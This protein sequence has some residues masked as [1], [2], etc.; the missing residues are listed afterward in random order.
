SD[1][2]AGARAS[3]KGIG[4]IA[5]RNITDMPSRATVG[6]A[7]HAPSVTAMAIQ[8]SRGMRVTASAASAAAVTGWNVTGGA[9]TRRTAYG[10]VAAHAAERRQPLAELACG[11][12]GPAAA[13]RVDAGPRLVERQREG[14]DVGLPRHAPALGLLGGHVRERPDDVARARERVV[15]GEMRDA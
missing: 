10:K 11:G 3:T 1:Q 9:S 6:E 15:A 14:V 2:S 4:S 8:P 12:G 5:A 7:S 13:H